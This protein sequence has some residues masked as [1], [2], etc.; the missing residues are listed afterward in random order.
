LTAS[1]RALLEE[2]LEAGERVVWAGKPAERLAFLGGLVATAGFG[3][4]ALILLIVLLVWIFAGALEGAG[5]VVTALILGTLIL[6]F[7]A[8]AAGWPFWARHRARKTFYAITTRRALGREVDLLG[9]A[10]LHVYEPAAVAG[11]LPMVFGKGPDAV[12]HLIFG[13]AVVTE[14]IAG[15][16]MRYY[17]RWGF[18][19][20][21]HATEVERVL[22]ETLIDP[23]LEQTYDQKQGG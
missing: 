11:V 23:F 17:R 7:A 4:V 1:D 3:L 6:A 5:L 22:R 19:N 8:A 21:P 20:L 12:G 18:F 16:R 9:R 13:A 10:K 15:M 2:Q 14:R